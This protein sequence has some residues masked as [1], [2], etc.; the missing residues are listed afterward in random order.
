[1]LAK[2]SLVLSVVFIIVAFQMSV[3]YAA[4][5][6]MLSQVYSWENHIDV[7]IKGDMNSDNISCKVSNQKAEVI[8]SGFL[9]DKG[10]TVRTTL[11]LDISTSIPQNVR[12]NIEL[13]INSL[14]ENISGNEQYKIV[15]FGEKLNTLREFS[16]DRYDLANAAKKIEFNNQYSRIYDALFNTIP[17]VK[18]LNGSPCYY[19]TVVITDGVDDAVAGVTK[20]ELYLR[21]QKE[22]YPIDVIAVKTAKQPEPNK[23][24][25]AL[26]RISGGKY[27]SFDSETDISLLTKS[28][29]VNDIFWIRA[30]I[31]GGLSD[32]SIRQVNIDDGVKS[33]QFDTKISAYDAP[34]T[35]TPMIPNP[36]SETSNLGQVSSYA[37]TPAEPVGPESQKKGILSGDYK[38]II[39]I[40]VGIAAG[41]KLLQIITNL[42]R[43]NK[44]KSVQP[45]DFSNKGIVPFNNKTERTEV[46]TDPALNIINSEDHC[47][48]LRNLNSADQIWDIS[49]SKGILIGRDTN[50]QVC[51]SDK[52]VSRKQCKIYINK[53]VTVENLSSSNKTQLNG[54]PLNAP[55][56]LKIGD[57]LKCGRIT[58]TVE[59]LYISHSPNTGE[60][61]KGTVYINI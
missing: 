49:L 31:P 60:L 11:L 18:P 57:K 20:E 3:C 43:G 29:V 1:M 40:V 2:K 33:V 26:T 27:Y 37:D 28:L 39:Y 47:I 38:M 19:R 23:E 58:L 24:L 34:S 15:T 9:A 42:I 7:F 13:F 30:N 36:F 14:I 8:E 17:D 16:S 32:G 44:N 56:R 5:N 61:N 41:I 59:S 51:I 54:K 52:S 45:E 12:G 55:S 46:L 35:D 6:T 4:G 50:C 10:I 21:L 48:R 25:P 53:N 22:T